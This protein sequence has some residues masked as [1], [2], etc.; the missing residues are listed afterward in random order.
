MDFNTSS[1]GSK[2]GDKRI[3][4]AIEQGN[5][6]HF[7]CC[8]ARVHKGA[9]AVTAITPGTYYAVFF[10]MSVT[11]VECTFHNWE[12][13]TGTV[14]ETGDLASLVVVGGTT[15]FGDLKSIDLT[16]AADVVILYKSC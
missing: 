2:S 9:A 4:D 3:K 7:G 8:G 12:D 6:G 15:L 16:N 11:L 13:D 14:G 1:A 5:C 10:P